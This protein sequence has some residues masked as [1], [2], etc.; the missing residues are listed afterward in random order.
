MTQTK[1]TK[2]GPSAFRIASTGGRAAF[3]ALAFG[4][5][6]CGHVT[7]VKN[8][9]RTVVVKA[10][11]ASG[12]DASKRYL[13]SCVEPQTSAAALEALKVS[14]DGKGKAAGGAEGSLG[15]QVDYAQTLGTLYKVG[16]ITLLAREGLFRLCEAGSNKMIKEGDYKALYQQ[17]F[18]GTAALLCMD[19]R[20]QHDAELALAKKEKESATQAKEEAEKGQAALQAR[21]ALMG[22]NPA[23]SLVDT[24]LEE[25]TKATE[26]TRK[27]AE[28][29]AKATKRVEA[30][31]ASSDSCLELVQ[32]LLAPATK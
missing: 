29:V 8:T 32:A 30:L 31:E 16:E 12:E 1:K 23:K 4:A 25:E 17:T 27:A 18:A 22:T 2:L 20:N 26:Q 6:G 7:T 13:F 21:K 24:L 14:V 15:A 3:A 10:D 9:E 19:S 28:K 5:M 11:P